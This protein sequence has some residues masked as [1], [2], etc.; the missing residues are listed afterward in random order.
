MSRKDYN[1]AARIL[2]ETAMPAELRSAL[3][4]RFSTMFSDDNP[5]FSPSRFR[6]ACEPEAVCT[7][8]GHPADEPYINVG[9]G[10]RCMD[11]CHLDLVPTSRDHLGWVVDTRG[12]MWE[13]FAVG[14]DVYRAP[15]INPVQVNGY[16][17][18]RW[19]CPRWQW[20]KRETV[21]A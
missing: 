2:R 15:H 4:A 9:A 16:R 19:F 6:E 21:A 5:R 20:D 7:S 8:C 3:V 11:Q 18:G 17:G 14:D 10:E 1:E 13:Y 12:G